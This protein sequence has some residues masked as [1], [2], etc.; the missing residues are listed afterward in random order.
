MENFNPIGNYSIPLRT[1]SVIILYAP[2]TVWTFDHFRMFGF[3]IFSSFHW[4]PK[5]FFQ[6]TELNLIYCTLIQGWSELNGDVAIADRVFSFS[7]T[8]LINLDKII[9]F[10][11]KNSHTNISK[12]F[13]FFLIITFNN[14]Y[15]LTKLG[16]F[17]TCHRGL[18]LVSVPLALITIHMH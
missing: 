5:G 12:P 3:S 7:W 14:Y 2:N 4:K 15:L 10:R 8:I 13:F 17:S 9:V 11:S 1:L 18:N 6:I 16:T